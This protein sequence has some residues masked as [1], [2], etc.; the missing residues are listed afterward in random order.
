VIEETVHGRWI[1]SA[2]CQD[3]DGNACG[4]YAQTI[5]RRATANEAKLDAVWFLGLVEP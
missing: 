3:R 4:V 5:A 2:F 1:F